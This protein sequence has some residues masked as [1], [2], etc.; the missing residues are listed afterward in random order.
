MVIGDSV[1]SIGDYAFYECDSLISVEIPDSV[2]TIGWGAFYFCTN[3]TI[4]VIGDGVTTI[5]DFA[6]VGCI[7]LTSVKYRGTEEEWSAISKGSDWDAN[8]GDY[9]ITY[10]YQGE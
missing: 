10:N 1:Y 8:T 3:L 7:R 9:T 4:V 2:T 5:G 6:F